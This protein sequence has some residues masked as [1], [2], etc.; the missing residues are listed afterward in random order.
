MRFGTGSSGFLLPFLLVLS[1]A[2]EVSPFSLTATRQLEWIPP[3]PLLL[4]RKIAHRSATRRRYALSAS[5]E[6]NSQTIR[7]ATLQ[8]NDITSMMD[9]NDQEGDHMMPIASNGVDAEASPFNDHSRH[10][11]T[12]RKKPKNKNPAMQDPAFLR[13]RSDQI[14]AARDNGAMSSRGMKADRKTFHFLLDA[15]AFSGEVDAAEQ[16]M[17]LLN[18]M[19]ELAAVD[20]SLLP[21][22]RS[23]TK[24][25]NA[26]SRAAAAN[27]GSAHSVDLADQV[28]DK[29]NYLYQS[30]INPTA[31]PN[32]FTYTAMVEAHANSGV[33][34]SARHA[35]QICEVMVQKFLDEN[36]PDVR[37]TA[38]AFNAVIN[39]YARIGEYAAAQ[40]AHA[41]FL[42]MES[43]YMS[44]GLE[45][46]KPNTY[47]YN[48]VI[49]AWANCGEER[50]VEEVLA[51]MEA[52]YNGGDIEVKPTTVTYNTV[53]DCYSKNAGEYEDPCLHS[54]Y[55]AGE[56]AERVLRQMEQLYNSG[57]NV[58]AK[59]N[60]RS[61]NTV[62]N[63]WAKSRSDHGAKRAEEI[64]DL[65]ERMAAAGNVSVRPDVHSFSTV[66]N[67]WARSQKENKAERAL[68]LLKEMD[69]LCTDGDKSMRPNVVVANAVMNACAFTTGDIAERNRAMEI[70]NKVFKAMESGAYG[71]PDQIT[72]G[73]F[74]K[75][76]ANQMP[77]CSTR[78]QIEEMIFQK[79]VSAGQVGNL[80][81]QQLRAT[82]SPDK[83]FQMVGKDIYEDHGMQD[84]PSDWWCNVVEGK[85]R[86]RR[87]F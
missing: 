18:R 45:E 5:R 81:L 6:E 56:K 38:R 53:I 84:L 29:M 59:P 36:D 37:P 61:Y 70:A 42:R 43:V 78:E 16:A 67:A 12:G 26:I 17:A 86:R 83:Y 28:F 8:Y 65:M 25:I 24:V 19:E 7:W 60:V 80:V 52:S 51:R 71:H 34:G 75:V 72:Y 11:W 47:N 46:V 13:K 20:A 32:T 23:Y 58:D 22:V 64:L 55:E 82:T 21:D 63:V 73:T 2:Q 44:T 57:E 41:L 3:Q 40:Q 76:C 4:R 35:E 31:K 30:G 87:N 50:A 85:W 69:R 49:S 66:I 15:W 77:E 39:A 9:E 14:L 10:Q 54:P 48:S 62:I 27:S 1:I 33:Q 68:N 74:L 79:C